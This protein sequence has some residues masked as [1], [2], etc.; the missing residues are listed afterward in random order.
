MIRN[1]VHLVHHVAVRNLVDPL[2]VVYEH[3][4]KLVRIPAWRGGLLKGCGVKGGVGG[5]AGCA[6]RC[7]HAELGAQIVRHVVHEV[8]LLEERLRL[9]LEVRREFF[10]LARVG[11]D[12][13]HF[14]E[15]GG[16][17]LVLGARGDAPA[18]VVDARPGL[19]VRFGLLGLL[20]AG[21]GDG[22]GSRRGDGAALVAL[23]L[24]PG[25]EHVRDA[26]LVGDV[27]RH[28]DAPYLPIFIA[29]LCCPVAPL[30]VI[31]GRNPGW[32]P[33]KCNRSS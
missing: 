29:L 4:E 33:W 31:G 26:V 21:R 14:S 27:R 17:R 32:P 30:A 13:L 7:R 24:V 12:L 16:E 25:P 18:E 23:P 1:L 28:R 8:H 20:E 15:R 5:G 11:A 3:L 10:L 9:A 19:P 22:A 6:R 2:V